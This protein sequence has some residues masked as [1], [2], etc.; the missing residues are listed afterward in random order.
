M[1][2]TDRPG[3]FDAW[4]THMAAEAGP[5]APMEVAMQ[6]ASVLAIVAAL[7][8]AKRHPHMP[9]STRVVIDRFIAGARVYFA[10]CPFTLEAITRGDDPAFDVR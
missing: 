5:L 7:Q 8:L 4:A 10:S 3:E 1:E 2:I 9:A 6:P